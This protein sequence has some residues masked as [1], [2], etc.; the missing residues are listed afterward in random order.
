M[1][2]KELT[3]TT[4]PQGKW[5]HLLSA[6][7]PID[8]SFNNYT[9]LHFDRDGAHFIAAID[10]NHGAEIR[11][12]AET[13]EKMTGFGWDGLSVLGIEFNHWL[14]ASIRANAKEETD[15]I[16]ATYADVLKQVT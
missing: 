8:E 3:P 1:N 5:A 7:H 15:K 13:I 11:E 10:S 2:T 12:K 6:D 14:N 9:I 4:Q 16:N